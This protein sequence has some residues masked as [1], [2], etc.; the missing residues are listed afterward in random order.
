[1]RPFEMWSIVA[2]RLAST[3]GWWTEVGDTS[4]PSRTRSVT[5]AIAGS[6]AQHSWVS[7][8]VD[9]RSCRCS[10]CSGRRTRRR[11]QPL[12]SAHRAMS[13]V[14]AGVC[15]GFGHTENCMRSDRNGSARSYAGSA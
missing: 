6:I 7:P 1:M 10:A 13:S 9:V 4:G 3:A 11:S 2:A 8:V 14:S 12:A 15:D 5:A